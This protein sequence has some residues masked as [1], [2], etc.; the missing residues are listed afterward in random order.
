MLSLMASISSIHSFILPINRIKNILF[1]KI[2]LKFLQK[3]M[4]FLNKRFLMMMNF[5]VLNIINDIINLGFAVR[6]RPLSSLP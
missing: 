4:V 6:K 2:N 1:I 3:I 5:L